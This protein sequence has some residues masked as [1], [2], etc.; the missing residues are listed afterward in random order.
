MIAAL[1]L[2]AFSISGFSSRD[3]GSN[4]IAIKIPEVYLFM[5]FKIACLRSLRERG[6]KLACVAASGRFIALAV[7][8][9]IE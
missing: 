3:G 8:A 5:V 2:K 9:L 7:D 4:L 6:Q 1:T